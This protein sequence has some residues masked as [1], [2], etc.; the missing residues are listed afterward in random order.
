MQIRQH[1]W[2]QFGWCVHCGA[3]IWERVRAWYDG[4]ATILPKEDTR[5]CIE[6]D[7]RAI[8]PEPT[9]REFACEDAETISARMT[10]I[11]TA[12]RPRCPQSP[13]RLLYDCLR[14]QNRCSTAC[15]LVN[16]W[17]GPQP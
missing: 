17:I 2:N 1:E 13:D 9:R 4:R 8:R 12:E 7:S 16:D 5:Q 10:G 15:P 11:R 14:S 3:A 6:R